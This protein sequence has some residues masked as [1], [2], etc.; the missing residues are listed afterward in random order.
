MTAVPPSD[1]LEHIR[2]YKLNEVAQRRA[3]VSETQLQQRLADLP[4]P[5]GFAQALRQQVASSGR[6][7]IAEFKRASPS[8]GVIRGDLQPDDVARA[9]ARSGAACLSVLTD[10]PSFQGSDADLIA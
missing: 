3:A 10:G 8:R 6:A 7:I 2:A 5:R 1:I 4:P 9:Y